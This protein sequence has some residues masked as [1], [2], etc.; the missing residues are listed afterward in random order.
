M[1][2]VKSIFDS[3][4]F[5]SMIQQ[6]GY[7]MDEK[8]PMCLIKFHLQLFEKKYPKPIRDVTNLLRDVTNLQQQKPTFVILFQT[9]HWRYPWQ[10]KTHLQMNT[11]RKDREPNKSEIML[12]I[13]PST[14]VG[15]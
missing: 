2:L 4:M 10:K 9:H 6:E 14:R 7:K 3:Q 15:L 5:Q 13:S 12:D 1:P 11:S 8:I